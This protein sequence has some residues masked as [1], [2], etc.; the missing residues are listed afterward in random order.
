MWIF[1]GFGRCVAFGHADSNIGNVKERKIVMTLLEL[2]FG[3]G[4]EENK[5]TKAQ[6]EKEKREK[7]RKLWEL[8]EEY[9]EEE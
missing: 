3:K 6:L 8:A 2:L 1:S 9:E 7:E 4:E 5:K